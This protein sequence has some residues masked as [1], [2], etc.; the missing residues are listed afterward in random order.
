MG[1]RLRAGIQSRYVSQPTIRQV[2][3]ASQDTAVQCKL[4][5]RATACT[6]RQF[7]RADGD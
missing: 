3:L 4:K 6:T 1:D 7:Y 5:W 2:G